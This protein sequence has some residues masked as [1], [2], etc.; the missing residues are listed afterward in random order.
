[1][2][3]VSNVQEDL[4]FYDCVQF[5]YT[6]LQAEE[7]DRIKEIQ[8][9]DAHLWAKFVN[10]YREQR[11]D[12]DKGWRGEYWGKMM[13]GACFIYKSSSPHDEHLYTLLE[14]TCRDML[15]VQ[16]ALGRFSTYSLDQE[17][18]GWD[19][20]CR[21]YIM[22]GFSYFL[23][24]C[25]DHQLAD[26]IVEALKK[27]AD[28]ILSKIGTEEEGKIV[29]PACTNAW[30]GINNCS[31]LEP[32]V[33]LYNITRE[34]KYLDFCAYIVSFGG[35]LH[36]NLFELAYENKLPVYEYPIT[37]AYEMISCFDGLAEYA[38][39]TGNEKLS[40]TVLNFADN[41]L[42][43]ERTIIG[44]LGCKDEHFDHASATQFDESRN[45]IMLETCVTVTW[46]KFMWQ[47]YRMTGD[48]KYMDEFEISMYNAMSA[49]LRRHVNPEEN[50]GIILP[51][52][53]YNPLRHNTRWDV[54]GGQKL[55]DE[56]SLY[57]CCVCISSAGFAMESIA[58]VAM[59]KD[60]ALYINL[61]RNG[62]IVTDNI[63]IEIST[64]YP[65]SADGSIRFYV[66][67]CDVEHAIYFRLPSW[68]KNNRFLL[69]EHTKQVD[70]EIL[71]YAKIQVTEGSTFTYIPDM[72]PY[73]VRPSDYVSDTTVDDYIAVRRGPITYALDETLEKEPIVEIDCEAIS[74]AEVCDSVDIVCHVAMKVVTKNKNEITLIDYAS[75]GQE[76]RHKI[77]AW[78]KKK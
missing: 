52:Y 71:N 78:I 28:Y 29:L 45:G 60:G 22:L 15:T 77:C 21:K 40:Q 70:C 7:A 11:D 74:N 72:T 18:N 37:K 58:S 3:C 14:E 16:D 63:E 30:G 19:I 8:L 17:F 59:D 47:L 50:G 13:R 62:K 66:R 12:S 51:V 55:I 56:N 34:K 36:T 65:Y 75:A 76:E 2:Y 43:N 35:T 53:S 41:V 38:K 54:V 23:E 1:M 10:Q 48:S 46:M 6:D 64:G 24:I 61:Y 67:K 73:A 57:G 9:Y 49:S 42:Q 25:K 33:F 44:C 20:W 31:I 27:H 69:D 39:I 68:S 26:E 4:R 32:F 5:A